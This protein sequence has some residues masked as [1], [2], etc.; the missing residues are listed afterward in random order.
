M[1]QRCQDVLEGK[2]HKRNRKDKK[3]FAFKGV[4]KCADC[5]CTFSSETKKERYTYLRPIKAKGVSC[6]CKQ[7]REEVALE[8]VADILK[9]LTIPQELMEL[10]RHELRTGKESEKE[11]HRKSVQLLQNDHKKT[12]E[13]LSKLLDVYIDGNY[14]DCL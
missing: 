4:L 6:G 13:R 8:Q 12:E 14:T 5:G 11:Y 7:L 9:T 1:Y 2:N 3:S 10:V